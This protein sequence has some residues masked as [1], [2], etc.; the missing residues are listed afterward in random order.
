SKDNNSKSPG[1]IYTEKQKQEWLDAHDALNKGLEEDK[2]AAEK[3]TIADQ[4]EKQRQQQEQ[5]RK[6]EQQN[7]QETQT[8]LNNAQTSNTAISKQM[9]LSMAEINSKK[10]GGATAEQL[11]IINDAKQLNKQNIQNQ[12]N[13]VNNLI[14]SLDYLID[15]KNQEDREKRNI[16]Q[17]IQ[18]AIE[19]EAR[20]L[21]TEE[22]NK[23]NTNYLLDIDGN[24]YHS[25]IINSKTWMNSNLDVSHFRNGDIIQEAKNSKE[26]RQAGSNHQPAWCYSDN[27]TALSKK[28]FHKL[29]NWYAVNDPRGLAPVGWHIASA[30]EFDDLINYLGGMKVAGGKMKS[31]TGWGFVNGCGNNESGFT[32]LPGGFTFGRGLNNTAFGE[33][34]YWWSSSLSSKG[35][36]YYYYILSGNKEIVKDEEP[37]KRY[38]YSVRCIKD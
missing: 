17:A 23:L 8:F 36:V 35:K 1:S 38:G 29:Y 24:K 18:N 12:N 19:D 15:K 34:G 11:K 22:K 10:Q 5:K 13:A 28:V 3:K 6:I 4:A 14:N 30:E 32:A 27:D 9:N 26:W 20:R 31:T 33:S 7:Q 2:K 16:N 25:V 21:Q 37:F